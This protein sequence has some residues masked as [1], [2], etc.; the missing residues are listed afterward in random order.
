MLTRFFITIFLLTSICQFTRAQNSGPGAYLDFIGNEY[1]KMTE[2]MMSYASAAAHSR[3]ARKI[4]KRRTDLAIQLKESERNIRMMKPFNGDHSLRDSIASY[5][6]ICAIVL[7]EDYAKILDMEDIAEQSYDAM[8]AYLLT[9]EKAN[10]KLERANTV[11]SEQYRQFA[12]DNG[13]TLIEN[14]SKLHQKMEAVGKVNKYYNEIYLLFF[15]SYKD[16]AY[17]LDALSRDDVSALQQSANTLMSSSSENLTKIGTVTAFKGDN[18]LKTT[19]QKMLAFYKEEA[20][21]ASLFIDYLLEKE[22]FDKIKEAF[23]AKKEKA[24]TKDDVDLYNNAVNDFNSF[25]GKV[26]RAHDELNKKR[27]AL[28]SNWNKASSAFLDSHTPK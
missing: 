15:K 5:M 25:L 7:N 10:E 14:E 4:D 16:E 9:K 13:I 22:K 3:S 26:N 6:R 28:L 23:D 19:C 1:Q 18:S 11:A 20:T 24:R 17:L 8:E 21:K 12:T 27:N 2:D